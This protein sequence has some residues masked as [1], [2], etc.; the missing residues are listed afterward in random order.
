LFKT[1]EL[2]FTE[3]FVTITESGQTK[4]TKL[5]YVASAKELLVYPSKANPD[6][7]WDATFK[8]TADTLAQIIKASGV[9]GA[10]DIQVIGSG[11]GISINVCDKKNPS[12]NVMTIPVSDEPQSTYTVDLRVENLKLLADEY[13]V[14]ISFKGLVK[15]TSARMALFV[16]MEASS[17]VAQN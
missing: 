15:F 17:K 6:P 12:A 5:K 4:G 8:L 10:P 9:I 1:P 7:S 14:N 3:K 2:T 13:T 16:A 11:D